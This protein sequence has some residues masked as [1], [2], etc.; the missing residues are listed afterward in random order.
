MPEAT[1]GPWQWLHLGASGGVMVSALWTDVR[2]GRISNQLTYP[3]MV[4]GLLFH[5]LTRGG[6]GVLD[7]ALGLALGFGLLF[8]GFLFGGIAGGDV[9]LA[10]ALGA[11][12]GLATTGLALLYMGLLAGAIS[13]GI[14]IWKGKLLRS[15]SRIGRYL[16]TTLTPFLKSEPLKPENSDTFPLGVSIVG[17]FAWAMVERAMGARSVFGDLPW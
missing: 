7:A 4:G 13:F 16:F 9:K 11:L 1:W 17:G 2:S 8:L 5:G 6:S 15:L 14:M 10:G 12:S 3:A